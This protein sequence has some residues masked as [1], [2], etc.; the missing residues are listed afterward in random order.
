MSKIDDG[1]F[2]KRSDVERMGTIMDEDEFLADTSVLMEEEDEKN[3]FTCLD[4]VEQAFIQV[5]EDNSL[6]PLDDNSS[7]EETNMLMSNRRRTKVD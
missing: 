4:D 6:V 3:R 5:E 1:A 2:V 7:D